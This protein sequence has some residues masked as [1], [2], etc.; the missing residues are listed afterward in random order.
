MIYTKP[1]PLGVYMRKASGE[2]IHVFGF[3]TL[4]MMRVEYKIR[5]RQIEVACIYVSELDK[6]FEYLGEL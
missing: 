3:E 1:L 6:H 4:N 5:Q 2:L